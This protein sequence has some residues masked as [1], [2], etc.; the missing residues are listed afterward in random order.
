MN[1]LKK[2]FVVSS[3]LILSL[4][5]LTTGISAQN[6]DETMKSLSETAGKAYVKPVVNGFGADL[7][8]GW[9]HKA[10]RAKL[11]SIDF[12][13]GVVAMG[14]LFEDKDKSFA[15][16]GTFRFTKDQAATLVPTSLPI[17]VQNSLINTIINKDYTV[18][19][20]GPTVVGDKN[21]NIKIV[22]PGD[23]INVPSVGNQ[24]IAA[25]TIDITDAKGLIDFRA[26]P[27]AAP[28][29]TVGT[30]LGTQAAFRYLP[31]LDLSKFSDKITIGKVKY[32]GWGVQHNPK[33]YMF[34]FIPLDFSLSYFTQ[35]LNV[36]E[37]LEATASAYGINVSKQLGPGWLNITPYAGYMLEKST[38]KFKYDYVIDTATN[39][40]QSVAFEM[41]GEN[42]NRITLG[43]GL[44]LLFLN[45]TADYNI[46]KVK[47]AT[48]G[49]WLLSF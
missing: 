37:I 24:T 5:L 33:A 25:K 13:F 9:Y 49:L 32:F 40:M 47:S 46:G 8:G 22:F 21:D 36:G 10:P 20:S 41:D 14:S 18:T 29:V 27:L 19:M 31:E 44:K 11:F 43:L 48:V 34:K 16:S 26:V 45:I 15:T 30:I 28:Q 2:L 1:G 12:E 4:F 6:L 39:K 17:S 23:V 35:K 7:N 38:L 42:E 3:V